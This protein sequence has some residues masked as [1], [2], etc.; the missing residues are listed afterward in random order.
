M[1][2]FTV[3]F[4]SR[5]FGPAA[6][7]RVL[8]GVGLLLAAL[9]LGP[10]PAA[11]GHG[12]WSFFQP[13]YT[14]VV[15]Q[16]VCSCSCCHQV[17]KRPQEPGEERT[18]CGALHS[19]SDVCM[20]TCSLM[21]TEGPAVLRGSKQSSVENVELML[22]CHDQCVPAVKSYALEDFSNPSKFSSMQL[23][24]GVPS[25]GSCKPSDMGAAQ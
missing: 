13:G 14:T 18:K 2:L 16:A 1:G 25:L 11:A 21:T 17:R 12:I 4:P 22:F 5:P 8:N 24:G 6:M 9:A 23:D 3:S 10:A 19:P 15:K 20:T 7:R